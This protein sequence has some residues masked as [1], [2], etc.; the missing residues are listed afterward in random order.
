M[1]RGGDAVCVCVG[2][3]GGGGGKS[4]VFLVDESKIVG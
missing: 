3:G 2:V 1:G 4:I